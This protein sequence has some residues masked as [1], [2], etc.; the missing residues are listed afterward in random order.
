M[1]ERRIIPAHPGAAAFA[2]ALALG[3]PAWVITALVQPVVH[4]GRPPDG[5]NG[6][7]DAGELFLAVLAGTL[8]GSAALFVV[9]ALRARPRT[10][11]QQARAIA[12]YAIVLTAPMLVAGLILT[13]AMGPAG[14]PIAALAAVPLAL[15]VAWV[16]GRA[17]APAGGSPPTS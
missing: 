17:P 5:F 1:A 8:A 7:A 6:M 9:A 14:G 3:V 16:L 11:A 12:V 2:G 4:A 13:L 15:H 10:S